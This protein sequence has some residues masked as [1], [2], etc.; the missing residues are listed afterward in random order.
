M[1]RHFMM[2]AIVNA[3]KQGKTFE[4]ENLS[5]RDHDDNGEWEDVTGKFKGEIDVYEHITTVHF[6]GTDGGD[7]Y[8]VPLYLLTD[9]SMERLYEQSEVYGEVRCDYLNEE[10]NWWCID[11]WKTADDNE[12]GEVVGWVDAVSGNIYYKHETAMCSQKVREVATA[13]QA[14][15]RKENAHKQ[16]LIGE[17]IA[18]LTAQ[19]WGEVYEQ[20][21][22]PDCTQ[23]S[24]AIRD[25]AYR[26]ETKWNDTPSEQREGYY[27]DM[28]DEFAKELIKEFK[29]MYC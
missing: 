29:A 26:F 12:E 21:R 2:T 8:E 24:C 1:E 17:T 13:K 6:F 23:L 15:V 27:I 11:A 10:D 16:G 3:A 20:M 14:E 22:E 25:A 7:D 19:V 18:M 4:C 28:I 9:K 5:H